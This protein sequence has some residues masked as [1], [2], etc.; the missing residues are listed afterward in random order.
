ML[1]RLGGSIGRVVERRCHLDDR[2]DNKRDIA[3]VVC[4]VDVSGAHGDVFHQNAEM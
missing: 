1:G 4:D 3:A 2:V